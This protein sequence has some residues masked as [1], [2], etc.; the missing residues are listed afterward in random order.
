MQPDSIAAFSAA[1]RIASY[2]SDMQVMHPNRARMVQVALEVLPFAPESP[3]T[4]LDLGAGTGIFTHAFLTRYPAARVV[5]V[6]GSAAMLEL[7]KARLGG[8]EQR[9]EFT[10]GDF[11]GLANLLRGR[12]GSVVFSCFALHHLNAKEKA[13]V[14]RA[15]LDFLQPGGWCF[16]ADLVVAEDPAVEARL[17][18]IRVAG[19]VARSAGR[20]PRFAT[21]GDTRRFLSE[22]EATHRDQP[23]TLAQDLHAMR[24]AGLPSPE[25]FW[26]EY[27]EAV[28]GGV[29]AA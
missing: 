28:I 3:I 17:Q 4:A 6:D 13:D 20:D 24:E 7:A 16:N 15:S 22:M 26:A 11:R 14:L 9:V 1:E 10:V 8:L 18:E 27:R 21:P 2:D 19:I 25:V 29:K 23:L 12:K 5:A